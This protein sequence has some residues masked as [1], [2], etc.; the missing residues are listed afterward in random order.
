[1]LELISSILFYLGLGMLWSWSEPTMIIRDVL[2][3]SSSSGYDNYN[4]Y[5]QFIIR[6]LECLPCS[7]FWIT[8]IFSLDPIL[9]CQV[10][11]FA[12]VADY[13]LSGLDLS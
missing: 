9:A 1:M 3:M 13:Y 12:Y 2:R 6:G 11:V 5:R 8:M 10:L 4:K 7:T